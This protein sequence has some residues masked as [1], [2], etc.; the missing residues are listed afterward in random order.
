MEAPA[1]G[2]YP[3]VDFETY[4][5]WD[6]VN[7]SR[8]RHFDKTPQH[9]RWEMLHP[10]ESS[11]YQALGHA[12]HAALLEPESF[13]AGYVV[14]P[15]VDRRTTVGKA[16]WAEFLRSSAGA[17]H[18]TEEE[19]AA[20]KGIRENVAK[21]ATISEAL[22]GKGISELS[23]VWID[24]ET[25]LKCKARIDRLAAIGSYPFIVD[26]K[27]THK[28]A[29]LHA[30]QTAVQQYRLHQQAAHYLA[31]LQVLRP[32]EDGYARKFAWVVCETE[33]PYAVRIF[34]AE[35]AALEIG[36][37]EVAAHLRAYADC[38]ERGS[39]P[40]WSEGM[41]LAGLPAWA[42]RQYQGD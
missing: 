11:K 18:I 2:I 8:L 21:H 34:E 36:R 41:E 5:R 15:D 16:A 7:H 28:P 9:A 35:D 31:G 13:A 6:A 12:I 42:Y 10:E 38:V 20:V 4:S 37:D 27:T 26:V 25:G 24:P 39:W 17:A 33:P 14:A 19:M 1:P 40:S 30:W 3:G 23:I 29:S 32:L 22:Y